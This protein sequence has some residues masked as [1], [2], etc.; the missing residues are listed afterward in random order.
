MHLLSPVAGVRSSR[1]DPL[2]AGAGRHSALLL[3]SSRSLSSITRS[4]NTNGTLSSSLS[5]FCLHPTPLHILMLFHVIL[6]LV[7]SFSVLFFILPTPF[8]NTSPPLGVGSGAAFTDY[9]PF[10]TQWVM[11]CFTEHV[12]D[13]ENLIY[14][15][16]WSGFWTFDCGW[17]IGS[18]WSCSQKAKVWFLD[19]KH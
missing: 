2:P 1:C 18:G 19:Q 10:S 8:S 3:R 16:S 6:L 13:L 12:K 17:Q 15:I 4:W 7:V 11:G 14:W 5:S 9:R